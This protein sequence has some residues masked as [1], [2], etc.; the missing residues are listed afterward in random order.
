MPFVQ[1]AH[2][3]HKG[4]GTLIIQSLTQLGDGRDYLHQ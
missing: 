3:R 2:G 1:I 4:D